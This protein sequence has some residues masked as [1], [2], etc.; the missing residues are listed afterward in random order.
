MSGEGKKILVIGDAMID[1]TRRVAVERIAPEAPC[2]VYRT[3]GEAEI[4][5]GGA[6]RVALQLSRLGARVTLMAPDGG[7]GIVKERLIDASSGAMVARLDSESV[8]RFTTAERQEILSAIAGQD[9]IVM[10]H[11]DKGALDG[12]LCRLIIGTARAEGVPVVADVKRPEKAL[13]RGA[14]IVKGNIAEMTALAGGATD[15]ATMA[16]LA[17]DLDARAVVMTEG[18]EG[19]TA[20]EATGGVTR[21]TGSRQGYRLPEAITGAGDVF[22]AVLAHATAAGEDVETALAEATAAASFKVASGLPTTVPARAL[23]RSTW[24]MVDD[25]K[26]IA[27]EQRGKRIVFTNGCFDV[28]HAG[29]AALLEGARSM[30]DCLVVGLNSD[31]SVER[32]KGAGR[33][34]NT[35]EQRAAVLAAMTDVDYIIAFEEDT[36]LRLIEALRPDVLVKGGDYSRETIVGAGV[37]E[38]YGGT[39]ATVPLVAGLSSTN[40]L[41]HGSDE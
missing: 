30:G 9:A 38:S 23:D 41:N 16:A 8:Q 13:Y 39:V 24:K 37:V 3:V 20:W 22:T 31:S 14:D 2:P 27:E 29:H 33:P 35:L 26:E 19:A 21:V 6:A 5:P 25:V 40:I 7:K 28:F 11:Y 15:D 4:L 17:V 1:I 10:S 18:R 12:P 32:L 36:P 34:V